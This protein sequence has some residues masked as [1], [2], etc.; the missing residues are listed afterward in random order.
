MCRIN[1]L[2]KDSSL[3]Q[4]FEETFSSFKCEGPTS[5]MAVQR[6]HKHIRELEYKSLR[7]KTLSLPRFRPVEV[8]VT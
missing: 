7:K 1:T 6:T 2:F 4:Y 8:S 3:I 5:E